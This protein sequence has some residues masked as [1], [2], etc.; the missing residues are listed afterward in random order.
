MRDESK[1][2]KEI[3]SSIRDL[4][5]FV[6]KFYDAVPDAG[7][8]GAWELQKQL[9]LGET[10]LDP[11]TKELIGLAVASHIKCQY[12]TYFHT[13]AAETNGATAQ[14]IREAIAMGGLTV[15]YS[16]SLSG[17]QVDIDTFKA[18]VEQAL[19]NISKKAAA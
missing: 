13:R 12:C 1:S 3:E 16:N 10:A 18:D 4:F 19:E 7:I 5:G 14:E 11:K 8:Q 2:R 6:P 17:T 9:Q 15:L